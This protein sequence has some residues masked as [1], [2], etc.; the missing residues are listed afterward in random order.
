MRSRTV[1][2]WYDAGEALY[3]KLPPGYSVEW[4]GG[5]G[6]GSSVAAITKDG[7]RESQT[8][9]KGWLRR[10]F[11]TTAPDVVA[12]LSYNKIDV[13]NPTEWAQ[14]ARA[15]KTSEKQHGVKFD[16]SVPFK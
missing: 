16:V 14:I 13:C 4:L 7:W 6:Y 15:V 9:G 11:S 2:G 10:I 3:G 5:D 1:Y 8:E 12:W